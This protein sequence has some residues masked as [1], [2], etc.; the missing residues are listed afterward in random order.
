MELEKTELNK[1]KSGDRRALSKAL[2]NIS[3]YTSECIESL[4][5][6]YLD[7]ESKPYIIG[8]MGTPGAGKSTFLNA[9]LNNHLK[10]K[11]GQKIGM[12]LV[13]PSD[14]LSKGAVL[15]DRVRMKDHFLSDDF[16]MRSLSNQGESL[17][18]HPLMERYLLLMSLAPFDTIFV[19][20]IGGGQA[21]TMV[22]NIVDKSLL[23]FDPNSG[24]G[25][26]H[27]K[28]GVLSVASEILISKADLIP[29]ENIKNSLEEW[30]SHKK[31]IWAANLTN[32]SE[33]EKL[34]VELEKTN[35]QISSKNFL[36]SLIKKE[37]TQDI[38]EQIEAFADNF[39]NKNELKSNSISEYK[40]QVL[41]KL[42]F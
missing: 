13:D 11:T 5:S 28:S 3:E 2:T 16:Y 24:D 22:T 26:Q 14:P 9:F 6:D 41:S 37:A 27:L 42:N 40:N 25:V 29:V 15:G 34:F 12:L 31:K 4:F 1:I 21:A 18:L 39:F 35:K 32:E 19:E 7:Q 33:L 10:K 17:E 8:L 20:T 30:S 36:K 23:I 38:F